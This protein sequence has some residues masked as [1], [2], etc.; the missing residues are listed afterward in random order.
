MW[1]KV[2]CLTLL[3]LAVTNKFLLSERKRKWR[4]TS[5]FS[6]STAGSPHFRDQWNGLALLQVFA[7]PI[8][9][10][11]VVRASHMYFG[12]LTQVNYEL[13]R[14]AEV[15]IIY[16]SNDNISQFKLEPSVVDPTPHQWKAESLPMFLLR[17]LLSNLLINNKD[18]RSSVRYFQSMLVLWIALSTE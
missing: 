13:R 11:W 14:S 8:T 15:N 16:S 12:K 2:W 4:G 3:I 6:A 18:C 1:N 5:R 7:R 17:V 10:S 9:V